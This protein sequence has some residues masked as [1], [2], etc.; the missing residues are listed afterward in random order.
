MVSHSCSMCGR[1]A[2]FDPTS[3][4]QCKIMFRLTHTTFDG[5]LFISSRLS[6]RIDEFHFFPFA[7]QRIERLFSRL[8]F[9]LKLRSFNW[10]LFVARVHH[11]RDS[12]V[13]LVLAVFFDSDVWMKWRKKPHHFQSH[14]HM[15]FVA[16]RSHCE[17]KKIVMHPFTIQNYIHTLA[18]VCMLIYSLFDFRSLNEREYG[19]LD[20]CTILTAHSLQFDVFN[21]EFNFDACFPLCV[22]LWIFID[23][24]FGQI[25]CLFRQK[26]ECSSR[27]RYL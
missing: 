18:F 8:R 5:C 12:S 1:H 17:R 19:T 24:I 10:K 13:S 26:D 11:C 25:K 6:D 9:T 27:D 16:N 22:R 23:A 14:F 4:I 7:C 21:L 20:G 2:L 15:V 3:R